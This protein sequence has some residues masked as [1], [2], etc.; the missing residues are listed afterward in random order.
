MRYMWSFVHQSCLSQY[1]VQD[2]LRTSLLAVIFVVFITRRLGSIFFENHKHN[3]F[4]LPMRKLFLERTF[5]NWTPSSIDPNT[6]TEEERDF[7]NRAMGGSPL[8]QT[9]ELQTWPQDF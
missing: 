8:I 4:I 3:I 5:F 9:K 7:K 1:P 2:V 6:L